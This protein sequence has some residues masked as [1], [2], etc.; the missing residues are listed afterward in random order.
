MLLCP[1]SALEEAVSEG[2]K[3]GINLGAV[4]RIAVATDVPDAVSVGPAVDSP[5]AADVLASCFGV[6]PGSGLGAG[7]FVPQ[8]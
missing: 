5:V 8:L 3:G 6:A 7:T 1:A 4:L 2:V